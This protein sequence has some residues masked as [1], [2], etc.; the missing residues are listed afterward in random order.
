MVYPVLTLL[1]LHQAPVG[2]FVCRVYKENP[3]KAVLA[4]FI[5]AIFIVVGYFIG[6][7]ISYEMPERFLGFFNSFVAGLMIHVVFHKFH[8]KH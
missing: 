6:N 5:L 8:T 7:K 4:I 3:I 1:V 2:L